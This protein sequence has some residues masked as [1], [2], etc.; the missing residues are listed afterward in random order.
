MYLPGMLDM[1]NSQ[2]EV[3]VRERL[4]LYYKYDDK[5]VDCVKIFKSAGDV[6]TLGFR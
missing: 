2:K 3:I 4:L 5:P 1:C 6:K